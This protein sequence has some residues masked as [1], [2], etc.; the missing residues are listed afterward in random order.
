MT[1]ITASVTRTDATPFE[2]LLLRM[3]SA[4]EVFVLRRQERRVSA[5]YR[6]VARTAAAGAAAREAAQA[7]G[8]IGLLPR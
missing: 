3:T 8:A 7:R 4:A 6:H 1:A 5:V 2:S